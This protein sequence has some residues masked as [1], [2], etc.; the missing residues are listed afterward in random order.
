MHKTRYSCTSYLMITEALSH[1]VCSIYSTVFVC[2]CVFD[3]MG[4]VKTKSW[5]GSLLSSMYSYI[6]S[7][8]ADFLLLAATVALLWQTSI[9][10]LRVGPAV[11]PLLLTDSRLVHAP[12]EVIC[13]FALWPLAGHLKGSSDGDVVHFELELLQEKRIKPDFHCVSLMGLILWLLLCDFCKM[14]IEKS[15]Q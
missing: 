10:R 2:L 9:H 7:G 11:I 4:C 8:H 15:L 5:K 13:L 1:E 6:E 12:M 14:L 3:N